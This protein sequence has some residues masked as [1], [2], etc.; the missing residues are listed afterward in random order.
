MFF[1]VKNDRN[2]VIKFSK[3]F[4]WSYCAISLRSLE[5]RLRK[6]VIYTIC[7]PILCVRACKSKINRPIEKVISSENKDTNAETTSRARVQYVLITRTRWMLRKFIPAIRKK[8]LS[9][10]ANEDVF[11]SLSAITYTF[12]AI[13]HRVIC[14]MI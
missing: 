7:K 13:K 2:A 4:T 3:N 1:F 14:K 10:I 5:R 9:P 8:K 6:M 12:I 11:R